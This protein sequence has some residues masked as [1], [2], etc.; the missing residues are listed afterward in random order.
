MISRRNYVIIAVVMGIIFILFQFSQFVRTTGNDYNTNQYLQLTIPADNRWK[1]MSL[2]LGDEADWKDGEYTL[3][4]GER[5]SD[6]GSIVTQWTL[7]TKRDLLVTESIS[8]FAKS[9]YARPEFI[10]V[11]SSYVNFATETSVFTDLA[12]SD[13]AIIF[14]N[15]PD[16][17]VI[18]NNKELRAVLGIDFI[19]RDSIEVEGIKLFGGFLLGGEEIYQPQKK[20]E[21]K[22]QDLNLK[23]PWY[24]TSGGTKTYMVGLMGDYYGDYE[25]ANDYIPAIIWRNSLSNGQV[26][27]VN[28]D[29][30]SETS[31]LGIL[32]AMAYELSSY[33]VYPIVNAQ[34]TLVIDF[35]IMANENDE[36]FNKI[37]SRSINEFQQNVI[38]PS[39][40][41]LSEKNDLKY[42]LF[43]SP[44]YNYSDPAEPGYENYDLLLSLFNE[45]HAELGLSL[46]HAPG[47]GLLDKL[48][49][50]KNYYDGIENRY[51]NTSAFMDLA[52]KADLDEAVKIAYVENVRTIACDEDIQLPILSYLT[53]TITLQSLTSNTKNF[54]YSRDLMLKSIETALGYDNA[55]LNMSPVAW[56]E[57]EKDQWEN[58]YNDMASSL[59]TFWHDFEVFDRTTL[60]ESDQRVRTFLNIESSSERVDDEITLHVSGAEGQTSWFI[61]RTHGA[62]IDA[63]E[64]ATYKKIE[65]D[66]YL[67][68]VDSE[69]V[70]IQLKSTQN[71]K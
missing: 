53:D 60:T 20:E 26:F 24:F 18:K 46:E 31:G 29:F 10:I 68:T 21:E 40:V 36:A 14:C 49:Y 33:Q 7:Y 63:I 5:D 28:G 67:L 44:K 50:D 35:P 51:E 37:Y 70:K 4:V 3:F 2:D 64:G 47:I 48:E 56:P 62:K 17:E 65:T 69:T 22:R 58:I 12:N 42:T 6:I 30:M 41:S 16:V 61:L 39:L 27:C 71:G 19:E 32:S 9:S 8:K 34:N 1:Q 55:K 57:S 43:M 66:A 52:D 15:L 13:N 45:R 11:D 25:Y 54:T 59:S 23:M 38:W